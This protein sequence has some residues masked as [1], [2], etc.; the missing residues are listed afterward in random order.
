MLVYINNAPKL[1]VD[2]LN[3]QMHK[4]IKLLFVFEMNDLNSITL[5]GKTFMEWN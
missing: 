5:T 4:K 3:Q 2:R 1:A